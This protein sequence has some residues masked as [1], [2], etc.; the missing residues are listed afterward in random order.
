MNFFCVALFHIDRFRIPHSRAEKSHPNHYF[1]LRRHPSSVGRADQHP[2]R[3]G[4]QHQE[5]SVSEQPVPDRIDPGEAEWD[6][7]GGAHSHSQFEAA[8]EGGVGDTGTGGTCEQ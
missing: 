1:L 3:P 5:V 2:T 7:F 8:H 6:R 4:Q